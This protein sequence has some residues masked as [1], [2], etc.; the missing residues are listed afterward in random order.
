M[1]FFYASHDHYNI[2]SNY[3]GKIVAIENSSANLTAAYYSGNCEIFSATPVSIEMSGLCSGDNLSYASALL[4]EFLKNSEWNRFIIFVQQQPAINMEYDS[5]NNYAKGTIEGIGKILESFFQEVESNPNIKHLT[6]SQAVKVYKE[7]FDQTEACYMVFDNILSLQTETN[8]YIPPKPKQKPPYPLTFFYYDHE[9]QLI[10]K[11]G[12][13]TPIE[14]KNYIIP[15]YE[16]KY[17]IEKEIPSIS[18]FHP[19]R[20]RDKLIMEFEIESLKRMPYGLAIWDDH[21]MF[22]LVSTNAR[23]VKWI[24]NYLLF[25][26]LNLEEGTNLIEISLRI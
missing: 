14:V 10:F 22:S 6:L 17:Y 3:Q 25:I 7:N 18:S 4:K 20:D 12:Q 2:P 24:G 15:P 19:M 26:R 8:F 16:S 5:Y 1:E 9:C 13:M 23:S 11:E 21:S